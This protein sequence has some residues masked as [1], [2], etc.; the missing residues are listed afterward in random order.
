[1]ID[2]DEDDKSKVAITTKDLVCNVGVLTIHNHYCS[3]TPPHP[4]LFF[5]DTN[6]S[7]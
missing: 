2:E 1:M 5:T 3:T 7:G 6:T 4:L